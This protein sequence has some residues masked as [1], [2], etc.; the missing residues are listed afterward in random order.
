MTDYAFSSVYKAGLEMMTSER[1][2]I[3]GPRSQIMCKIIYLR[4]I[5]HR[6]KFD[7]YSLSSLRN[8]KGGPTPQYYKGQNSP[9]EIGLNCWETK[10]QALN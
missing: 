10:S 5:Y 6:A 4:N 2:Q 1:C 3:K 7:V 8:A 9:V